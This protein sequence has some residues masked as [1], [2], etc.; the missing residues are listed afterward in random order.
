[1]FSQIEGLSSGDCMQQRIKN[2][3][4]TCYISPRLLC[5]FYG[6]ISFQRGDGLPPGKSFLS[7]SVS[8]PALGPQTQERCFKPL[9]SEH[10]SPPSAPLSL[11]PCFIYSAEP[12]TIP[13]W[14]ADSNW[15]LGVLLGWASWAT[16]INCVLSGAN[17]PGLDPA[18]T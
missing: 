10:S 11:P 9:L 12:P 13:E 16:I 5:N 4:P 7:A 2:K 8:Y 1:M 14:T 15:F 6:R 3:C 18:G 17:Q